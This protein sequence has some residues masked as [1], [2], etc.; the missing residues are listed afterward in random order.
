MRE[1]F[2]A[3]D[4]RTTKIPFH[5]L[6]QSKITFLH[7]PIQDGGVTSDASL[8][9]LAEDCCRRILKGEVLYVH[10]WGGHGRTGTLLSVMLALLYG[11][12]AE[13][14]MA[15][16]QAA[17]DSRTYPQGVRSPQTPPQAAQV[18]RIIE[19]AGKMAAIKAA[20]YG[21]DFG[22]GVG[23]NALGTSTGAASFVGAKVKAELK[24]GVGRLDPGNDSNDGDELIQAARLVE[25]G[26]DVVETAA[27]A[28]APMAAL[29][30]GRKIDF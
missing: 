16:T 14:A 26:R 19:D 17:H 30:F 10:C 4:Q 3:R 24:T 7:L 11:I 2:V 23:G 13:E 1:S 6:P 5:P 15:A 18:R 28:R 25:Y 21:T 27:Q 22:S 20:M 9:R 8:S 12:S 29:L